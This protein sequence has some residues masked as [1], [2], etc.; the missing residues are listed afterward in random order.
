[1]LVEL[2]ANVLLLVTEECEEGDVETTV[3][4]VVAAGSLSFSGDEE[5]KKP[6]NHDDE[7]D[8]G[9]DGSTSCIDYC[10]H[11]CPSS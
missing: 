11:C 6:P 1:M 10:C 3:A 9:V 7:D 2:V 8:V 5:E 4:A